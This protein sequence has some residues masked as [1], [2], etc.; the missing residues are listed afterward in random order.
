MD[1]ALRGELSTL[2]FGESPSA[3]VESRLFWILEDNV[4]EK[5]YLS[6]RACQGILNRASRRGKELPEILRTALLDMIEWWEE[7]DSTTTKA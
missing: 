5:Y 3:A 4:P 2:N 1:G 7:Q 6:E